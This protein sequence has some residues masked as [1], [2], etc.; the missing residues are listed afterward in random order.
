MSRIF[1]AGGGGCR[2]SKRLLLKS[3]TIVDATIIDAPPSTKNEAKAR[4]PE[5]RQGKKKQMRVAFWDE[6]AR[7]HLIGVG[8]C[9]PFFHIAANVSDV[10]QM[11]HLLHGSESGGYG[12]QAYWSEGHR[13]GRGTGPRDPLSHQPSA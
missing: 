10:S 11:V 13:Q 3:G 4:D 12:D 9:T 2:Q 7:G 8:S 6:G 1:G 5:M